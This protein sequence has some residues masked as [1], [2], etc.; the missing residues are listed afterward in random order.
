MS[1]NSN[2]FSIDGQGDN[3]LDRLRRVI[4][5]ILVNDKIRFPDFQ[6]VTGITREYLSKINVEEKAT[7]Y[8]P[9]MIVDFFN[10]KTYESVYKEQCYAHHPRM[11]YAYAHMKT[12]PLVDLD[13]FSEFDS[14]MDNKGDPGISE[15]V[16]LIGYFGKF[17]ISKFQQAKYDLTALEIIVISQ[18]LSANKDVLVKM[19]LYEE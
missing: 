17:A 4:R 6:V 18:I 8:D 16:P 11:R 2:R 13:I 12:L 14:A 3:E 15:V 5:T 19:Q 1:K 10:K 7:K 9:I